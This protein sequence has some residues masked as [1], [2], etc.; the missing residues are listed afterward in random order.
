MSIIANLSGDDNLWMVQ[1]IASEEDEITGMPLIQKDADHRKAFVQREQG[2]LRISGLTDGNRLR[3]FAADGKV[4]YSATVTSESQFVALQQQG[5][6]LI[7][8]GDEIFKFNF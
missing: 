3:V 8:T 6:Y 7:S 1:L 2:G 4:V 5:V